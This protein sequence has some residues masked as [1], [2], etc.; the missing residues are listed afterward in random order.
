MA[1]KITIPKLPA[2]VIEK[3]KSIGV[4]LE[5]VTID[6]S[7]WNPNQPWWTTNKNNHVMFVIVSYYERFE[8]DDEIRA[9]IL[10]LL[11]VMAYLYVTNPAYRARMIWMTFFLDAYIADRQFI[12]NTGDRIILEDWADP[13]KWA[14]HLADGTLPKPELIMVEPTDPNKVIR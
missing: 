14:E 6:P 13:R 10:P 9:W 1:D 8:K 12:N 5:S 4:I 11:R 2:E 7:F 3:F